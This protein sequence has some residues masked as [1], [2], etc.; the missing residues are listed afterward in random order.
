MARALR[1]LTLVLLLAAQGAA[2]QKDACATGAEGRWAGTHARLLR[3][4]G[5]RFW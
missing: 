2:A 3:R 4:G 5:E 1:S